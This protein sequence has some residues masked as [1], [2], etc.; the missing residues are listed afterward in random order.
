M[1]YRFKRTQLGV[2]LIDLLMILAIVGMTIAVGVPSAIQL[3]RQSGVLAAVQEIRALFHKTRS[4]AIASARYTAIKFRDEGD[5]WTY[6]IYEDGDWDGVRN[7]DITRGIDR[8]IEPPREVLRSISRN[9]RIGMPQLP[10]PNPD[11]GP[12]LT[13]LTSPV[14]F[15]RSTLC[16]F[17]PHG[18]STPGS[19]FLTDGVNRVALVRVYGTTAK[20]RTLRYVPAK[21]MWVDR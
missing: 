1:T 13:S 16:S 3:H 10:V 6:S 4:R 19:I 5:T 12:P 7:D 21:A 15:N 11:G 8:M 14:R 18:S 9:V 17:S 20:I 2:S